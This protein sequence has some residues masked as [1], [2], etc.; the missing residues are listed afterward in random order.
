MHRRQVVSILLA[1]VVAGSCA[2]VGDAAEAETVWALAQVRVFSG[3]HERESFHATLSLDAGKLARSLPTHLLPKELAVTVID[4]SDKSVVPATVT[5]NAGTR[6]S[7]LPRPP[8][9]DI[10]FLVRGPLGV[11]QH[12]D[13]VVEL[14]RITPG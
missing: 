4:A 11:M 7:K 5:L 3:L 1:L 12:R 9:L 6:D 8:S 2:S 10:S 14:G 13:F